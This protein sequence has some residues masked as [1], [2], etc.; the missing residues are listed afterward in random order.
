MAL[1]GLHLL[2]EVPTSHCYS[3]HCVGWVGQQGQFLG[4][5][6]PEYRHGNW[7]WMGLAGGQV[8]GPMERLD[9]CCKGPGRGRDRGR[10]R[11]RDR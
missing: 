7:P 5:L 8:N 11:G 2:H 3:L 9:S 6:Q 10:G 1:D 4:W